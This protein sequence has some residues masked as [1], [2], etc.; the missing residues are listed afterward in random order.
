MLR[1]MAAAGAGALAKNRKPAAA[2]DLI[3]NKRPTYR[4]SKLTRLLEF[5][6][7]QTTLIATVA[8]HGDVREGHRTLKFARGMGKVRNPVLP[9][10][11]TSGGSPPPPSFA[12]LDIFLSLPFLFCY[13]HMEP[14]PVWVG[15]CTGSGPQVAKVTRH[16]MGAVLS[17]GQ[18]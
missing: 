18:V 5:L 8:P 6:G 13:I 2:A 11:V 12:T 16:C 7:G 15:R 17:T 10:K 9:Q 1:C 3:A 4:G 14:W